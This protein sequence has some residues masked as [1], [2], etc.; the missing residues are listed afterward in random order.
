M[1]LC[2]LKVSQ[3]SSVSKLVNIQENLKVAIRKHSVIYVSQS[4][5]DLTVSSI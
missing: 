1:S 2:S 4:L 5:H 3:I